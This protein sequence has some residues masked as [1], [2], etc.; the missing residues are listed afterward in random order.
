MIVLSKTVV[1]IFEFHN[2]LGI[3]NL[4]SFLQ[5]QIC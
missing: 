4:I 3:F 2:I 1:E 5:P